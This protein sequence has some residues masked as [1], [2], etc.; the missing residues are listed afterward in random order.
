MD[1]IFKEGEKFLENQEGT[2]RNEQGNAQNNYQ[3]SQQNAP[4]EQNQQGQQ[5]QGMVKNFEQKTGDA[6]I[7]Q[8]TNCPY[9]LTNVDVS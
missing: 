2:Q 6:Y 3:D 7:N 8:G 5:G 1:N 4:N 9:P